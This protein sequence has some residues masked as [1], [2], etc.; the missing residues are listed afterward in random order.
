MRGSWNNLLAAAQSEVA[1]TL[2]AL[3]AEL[4]ERAK[5]IPVTCESYPSDALIA[6]GWEP[7]LLG[8]YTGV[9]FEH[10]GKAPYPQQIILFLENLW[11][12]ADGDEGIYREE[13]RITYLRTRSLPWLDEANWRPG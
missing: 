7:D 11:D 13:V 2:E 6:D 12:Y 4:R 8:L 10:E 1:A 9:P 5:V 3:P